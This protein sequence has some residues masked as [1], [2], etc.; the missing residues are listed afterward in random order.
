MGVGGC[1]PLLHVIT[2]SFKLAES[3]PGTSK[4]LVLTKTHKAYT[5]G[6]ALQLLS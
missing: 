6:Q 5:Q 2:N 1:H 3:Y 4:W